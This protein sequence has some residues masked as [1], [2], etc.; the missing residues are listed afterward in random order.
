MKWLPKVDN[1]FISAS[2]S[3]PIRSIC[4]GDSPIC[5]NSG[6]WP[7]AARRPMYITIVVNSSLC[8]CMAILKFIS[9]NSL[10][11]AYTTETE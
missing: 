3:R 7:A 8:N 4:G 9:G 10:R 5:R 2:D 11:K 6:S 1:S